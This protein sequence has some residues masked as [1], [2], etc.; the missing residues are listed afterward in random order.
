[1]RIDG[2]NAVHGC[3]GRNAWDKSS[4]EK[5][6]APIT[7]AYLELFNPWQEIHFI[8]SDTAYCDFIVAMESNTT[9]FL[10]TGMT[11]AT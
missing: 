9:S 8:P 7:A 1:M 3:S 10:I 6:L 5:I 11:R 4:L 2:C